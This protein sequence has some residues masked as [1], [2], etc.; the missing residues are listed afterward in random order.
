MAKDP[1]FLFYPGDY[2]SGTM[3]LD[4]ECKGAYV[5]L[6][7]LQFQKDHMSLH[8]IKHMLGHK[9]EHIWPLIRD[10]FKEDNGNFWN[11]RLRLE[12]EKRVKFTES[13][14]SNRNSPKKNNHM[15][16]H[17]ENEN[18]NENTNGFKRGLRGKKIP[19]SAIEIDGV[20]LIAKFKDGTVQPLGMGQQQRFKEGNYQPH[21]IKQ[22]IIE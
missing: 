16:G 5:D 1:A 7:M 19:E 15:I 17:M 9:F 14:R 13:R 20:N 22:G 6:L 21:Y 8:M 11:E 12:K 10:K 3:H 2:V 18:E 4:L